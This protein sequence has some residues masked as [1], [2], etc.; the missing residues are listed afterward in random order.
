MCIDDFKM[1][2]GKETINLS[3]TEGLA[4]YVF[5]SFPTCVVSDLKAHLTGSTHKSCQRIIKVWANKSLS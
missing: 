4:K 2:E 3:K 5:D 1:G